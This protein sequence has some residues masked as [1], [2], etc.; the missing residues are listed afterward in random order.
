MSSRQK[1]WYVYAAYVDGVLRYIGKGKG[2]RYLHCNSGKSSCVELNRDFFAGKTI[3]VEKVFEDLSD[4]D[5]S[6]REALL[7]QEYH[8]KGLY[9]IQKGKTASQ[10]R[11]GE[12]QAWAKHYLQGVSD[13][14]CNVTIHV[15]DLRTRLDALSE[16]R[17]VYHSKLIKHKTILPLLGFVKE[18]QAMRHVWTRYFI[19]SIEDVVDAIEYHIAE[20]PSGI[21]GP[22]INPRALIEKYQKQLSLYHVVNERRIM[23]TI[24]LDTRSGDVRVGA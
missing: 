13:V 20:D 5:A 1:I 11:E 2:N 15:S 6:H 22:K 14:N 16:T 7:L 9:N 24:H 3:E 8:G 12:L 19:P 23:N 21:S 10:K 4:S 17:P 18:M